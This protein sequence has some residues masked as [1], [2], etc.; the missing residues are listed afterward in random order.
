MTEE[1]DYLMTHYYAHYKD[2]NPD[3]VPTRE[4]IEQALTN[5][6]DKF[7]KG[8]AQRKYVAWQFM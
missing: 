2:G 7:I 1:I 3:I 5:H 8:L 4:Q 6:P